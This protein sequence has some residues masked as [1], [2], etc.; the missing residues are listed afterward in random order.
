MHPILQNY[1]DHWAS[2]DFLDVCQGNI[3]TR[4]SNKKPDASGT[5]TLGG[6]V[7]FRSAGKRK[8]KGRAADDDSSSEDSSA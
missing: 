7:H 4:G 3:A 6:S 8:G 1:A 2:V 5:Y